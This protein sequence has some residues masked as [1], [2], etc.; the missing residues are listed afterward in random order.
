VLTLTNVQEELA[1]NYLVVVTDSVGSLRSDVAVLRVVL[2]LA[3]VVQPR[4]LSAPIG[5]SVTFSVE[6][7][8]IPVPYGFNWFRGAVSLGSNTLF[9]TKSF[10]TVT[11]VQAAD[12][13][14]YRA[15]IKNVNGQVISSPVQLT[16]LADFDN[17]GL[18]DAYEQTIG[19]NTNN[20]ADA[21]L[22]LD[23]DGV[24]NR[25]EYIA[26]T[27]AADANSFLWI[28]LP[29]IGADATLLFSARSNKTYTVQY[30]DDVGAGTWLKVDDC[31]A[32]PSNHVRSVI[33]PNATAH[34]TYRVVTP[35]QP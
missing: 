33:D 28:Q 24:S 8:G 6:V 23:G 21:L 12:A 26:G 11:N 29:Q 14:F 16:M 3:V 19:L 35:R 13:T 20:A 2:P 15:I 4:S 27:D 25:E 7:R 30:T 31:V 17:D 34:R 10:L 5:G 22:D 32:W 1:G 9:S 18:P